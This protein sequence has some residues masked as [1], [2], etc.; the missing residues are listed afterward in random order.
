MDATLVADI[1]KLLKETESPDFDSRCPSAQ[2][3]ASTYRRTLCLELQ[4][5]LGEI[6]IPD[7]HAWQDAVG[8]CR[9]VIAA[10]QDSVNRANSHWIR[11]SSDVSKAHLQRFVPGIVTAARKGTS[12]I[13]SDHFHGDRLK[14]PHVDKRQ[15]F[16]RNA[17]GVDLAGSLAGAAIC[18]DYAAFSLDNCEVRLRGKIWI[19]EFKDGGVVQEG[20]SWFQHRAWTG[21]IRTF[22]VLN[23][24][25]EVDTGADWA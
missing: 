17:R 22:D 14:V 4:G 11:S 15:S 16:Y 24:I 2:H 18:D 8:Y 21:E 1:Y 10:P 3:A 20:F 6:T 13:A 5:L 25:H 12:E 23:P 9:A 19:D 7:S